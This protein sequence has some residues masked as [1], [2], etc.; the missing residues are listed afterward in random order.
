[1]PR[2]AKSSYV[3]VYT[4]G[5][6]KQFDSEESALEAI[7]NNNHDIVCVIRGELVKFRTR[8]V[9]ESLT[10]PTPRTPRG[11]KPKDKTEAKVANGNGATVTTT[12]AATV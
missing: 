4:D 11:R 10:E 5:L 1:M 9:I 3:I 8:T 2:K 7:D 12:K 6:P